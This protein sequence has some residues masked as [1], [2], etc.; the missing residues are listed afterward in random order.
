MAPKIFISF[1][2]FCGPF[3]GNCK[4][5][6]HTKTFNLADCQAILFV[7][8]IP[9]GKENVELKI[10]RSASRSNYACCEI[11]FQLKLD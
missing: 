3:T 10:S 2:F 5:I 8:Q 11:S 9:K 7:W 1:A 4:K 6:G